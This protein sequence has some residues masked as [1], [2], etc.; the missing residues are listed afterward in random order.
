[1]LSYSQESI[2][3][4]V[5]IIYNKI[6]ERF[7]KELN[8]TNV[9]FYRD[10]I[11]TSVVNETVVNETDANNVVTKTLTATVDVGFDSLENI[12]NKS[13]EILVIGSKVRVFYDRNTMKNAYI[14]VKF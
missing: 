9:E 2:D 11:V 1:M 10:G 6:K 4:L 14:G 3:K 13:G 5:D 12:Q 7:E 8:D